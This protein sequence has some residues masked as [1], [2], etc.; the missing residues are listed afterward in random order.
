MGHS[1]IA[2]I[3]KSD[4]KFYK[5]FS[6]YYSMSKFTTIAVSHDVYR[7]LKK[8][9]ETISKK[10]NGIIDFNDVI[11]ELIEFAR[12]KKLFDVYTKLSLLDHEIKVMRKRL[13]EIISASDNDLFKIWERKKAG[14]E[15][16]VS[17]Q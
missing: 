5:A 13:N 10:R 9:K 15:D 1:T 3:I 6:Q 4:H 11:S 17:P 2:H 16:H 14:D 12:L 7:Q 8:L